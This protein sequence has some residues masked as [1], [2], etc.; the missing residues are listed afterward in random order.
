[1][2]MKPTHM[3]DPEPFEVSV[4]SGVTVATFRQ[5]FSQLD[6]P[7]IDLVNRKLSDLAAGVPEPRLLLDMTQ[8]DFFGS[9]F[10]ES[11]FRAWKRLQMRP[12]AKMGLCGLNAHCREVLEITHLDK[13]WLLSDT[14]AAAI[15]QLRGV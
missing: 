6:E 10:I 5:S 13:L 15:E 11:M 3:A 8:V 12:G 9:S 4:V 14:A 7:V 1:M 2:H